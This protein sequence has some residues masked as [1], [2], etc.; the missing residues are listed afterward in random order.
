MLYSNIL[1]P[2]SF[3]IWASLRDWLLLC[4]SALRS[5]CRRHDDES[6]DG[7]GEESE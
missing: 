1:L 4:E 6:D 5:V 3:R 7:E 2:I